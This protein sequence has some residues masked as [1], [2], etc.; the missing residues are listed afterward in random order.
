MNNVYLSQTKAP[1]F[2]GPASEE[3]VR[4][5]EIPEQANRVNCAVEQL[6]GAIQ[7]LE[8]RLEN[9]LAP[10]CPVTEPA[11]KAPMCFTKFGSEMQ[12]AADRIFSAQATIARMLDRLQLC[13]VLGLLL[14][15]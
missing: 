10:N 9:S 3:A 8:N 1:H 2:A 4:P 15:A 5:R 7:A 12:T 14:F 11:T 13:F 6:E